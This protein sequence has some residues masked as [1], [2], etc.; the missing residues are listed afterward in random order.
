MVGCDIA[1]V[2]TP[3]PGQ[4][5][6]TPIDQ[7]MREETLEIPPVVDADILFVA[8]RTASMVFSEHRPVEAKL[9]DVLPETFRRLEA[10]GGH[11]QVGLIDMSGSGRLMGVGEDA[12]L[13]TN[14]ANDP[15][16]RLVQAW[17]DIFPEPD[18]ILDYPD[19]A[20]SEFGRLSANQALSEPVLSTFNGSFLREEAH[21][22]IV[23]LSDEDDDS[24]DSMSLDAFELFL[25]GLKSSNEAIRVSAV[26]QKGETSSCGADSDGDSDEFEQ[27]ARGVEFMEITSRF[28][29]EVI[30][31]CDGDYRGLYRA[32]GVDEASIITRMYLQEVPADRTLEMW[33][34]GPAGEIIEGVNVLVDLER[35]AGRPEL[36]DEACPSDNCVVFSW[37][38]M[39]NAVTLVEEEWPRGYTA[40]VRYIPLASYD[41]ETGPYAEYGGPDTGLD[42][43]TDTGEE[44]P[45]DTGTSPVQETGDTAP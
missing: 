39:N 12:L 24:G 5:P 28:D 25:K 37:N 44:P 20:Q 31:L 16:E 11:W 21:L 30:D 40:H 34:E 23:F 19:E 41:G 13:L 3:P 17:A 14:G 26:V 9:L 32:F 18:V 36:Y 33:F 27:A 6:G 4:D 2:V 1:G 38:P 22:N 8:D 43:G 15:A 35:Q 42:T 45:V 29:G 7:L 10:F